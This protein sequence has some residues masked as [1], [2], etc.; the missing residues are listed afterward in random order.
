[1]DPE[2]LQELYN[3]ITSND[4]DWAICNVTIVRDEQPAK[5]RLQLSDGVINVAD[6]RA[7]FVHGLMRFHYDNAN[8]NKLFKN[9]IIL[10]HQ[11][12]FNE[13]MHIW[14]DLLFNLQYLQYA[15]KVAIVAKPLYNYR[16]LDTS[17]Y[18]GDTSNKV[19][20]FN[21]LFDYYVEFGNRF[22]G[23]AELEAFKA[24]MARITYN[25]LLYQAEVQVNKEHHFFPKVIKGY[26]NELKRFNPAIFNYTI[27]ERKGLQGIKRQI[28]Q[29][30]QFGLFALIIASKPFLRKPY[31]FLRRLLQR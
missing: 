20:Q 5:L 23:T 27:A 28:L 1:M 4:C 7:A 6:D 17:L 30:H 31:H 16:I 11:L 22:A 9:S 25:Q 19:P 10:D 24:E 3:A 8:W 2:M 26:R 15:N 14:E 21:K 12:R 29:Q 18:S 13:Q